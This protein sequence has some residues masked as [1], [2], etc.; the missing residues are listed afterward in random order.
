MVMVTMVVL[1][2]ALLDER[3]AHDFMQISGL[4]FQFLI[5]DI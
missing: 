2:E 5:V 1:T 3:L 4:L